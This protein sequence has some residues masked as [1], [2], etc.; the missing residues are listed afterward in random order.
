VSEKMAGDSQMAEEKENKSRKKE[1]K[2]R[3]KGKF[4]QLPG[5]R[6][7]DGVILSTICCFCGNL[8]EKKRE[9]ECLCERERER[10]RR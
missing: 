2:K 9:R 3:Q 10:E 5:G 1:T 4:E 8:R 6:E 7:I